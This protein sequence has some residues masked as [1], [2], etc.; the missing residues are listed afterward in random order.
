MS[1]LNR[2]I[3]TLLLLA[4]FVSSSL[5]AVNPI[6]ETLEPEY[7]AQSNNFESYLAESEVNLSIPYVDNHYGSADG[8]ID[9]WEYSYRYTDPV[10]G[11]TAYLEHNGTAM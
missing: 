6:T 8:I 5:M 1:L 4:L 3:G 9:P 2:K 10:T 7:L 11:V